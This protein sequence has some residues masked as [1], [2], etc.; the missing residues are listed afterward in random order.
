MTWDSL[1]KRLPHV[2][3]AERV[4]AGLLI[5]ALLFGGW[6]VLTEPGRQ[7]ARAAQAGADAITAQAGQKAA[8][9]AV[10]VVVERGKAEDQIDRT[11]KDNR[12][13]ILSAPGANQAVDTGVHDAGRRALC[14]RDAYRSSAACKRLLDAHP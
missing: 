11:T 4:L 12:D 1:K 7:R 5:L 8:G 9:D 14:L 3:T 2:V 10:G 13:A 6:W